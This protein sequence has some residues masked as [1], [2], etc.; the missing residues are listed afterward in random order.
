MTFVSTRPAAEAFTGEVGRNWCVV[1]AVIQEFNDGRCVAAG[2]VTY[3]C[4]LIAISII[5]IIN[6]S[7]MQQQQQRQ[8]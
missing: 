1:Y 7:G 5:I 8:Q 6:N 2:R 4:I 3:S